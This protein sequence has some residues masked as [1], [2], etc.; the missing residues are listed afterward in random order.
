[1]AGTVEQ[2][3]VAARRCGV[4]YRG[5]E[6]AFRVSQEGYMSVEV[7]HIDAAGDVAE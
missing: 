7:E 4:V 3:A 2:V 1:M 5:R 6:G